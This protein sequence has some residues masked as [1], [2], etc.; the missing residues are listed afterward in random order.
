MVHRRQNSG[1]GREVL[2]A[3]DGEERKELGKEE[4]RPLE[5]VIRVFT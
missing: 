1:R 5:S 2:Q 4:Y 3:R